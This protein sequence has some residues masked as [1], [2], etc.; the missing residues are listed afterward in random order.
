M[1]ILYFCLMGSKYKVCSV[2]LGRDT[3]PHPALPRP[4]KRGQ[5]REFLSP[6]PCVAGEGQGGVTAPRRATHLDTAPARVARP[7]R[8]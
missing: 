2:T 7:V 4:Q 1:H 6:L 5:G 3:S 8:P